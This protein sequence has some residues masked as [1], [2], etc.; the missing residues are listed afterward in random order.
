[1][2]TVE[3]TKAEALIDRFEQ[4]QSEVKALQQKPQGLEQ[5]LSTK[6]AKLERLNDKM[7]A[8][9][10]KD[11]F[12]ELFNTNLEFHDVYIN[13]SDND[14]LKK[15]IFPIKHRL[16][17]FP[18]QNYIAEWEMRNCREHSQFISC[19]KAKDPRGAADS[20]KK[21]HW[22]FEFQEDYIRQFYKMNRS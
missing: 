20:L 6:R 15:F 21:V 2:D 8:D 13:L 7:M 17:D 4:F 12:H 18:R 19:L 3:T 9:I 14:L 22:S 5:E 1:M 11:D 16:Y 10:Q